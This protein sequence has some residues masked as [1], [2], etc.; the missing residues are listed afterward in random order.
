MTTR[1]HVTEQIQGT[2]TMTMLDQKLYN[3]I[4][5]VILHTI[6]HSGCRDD[7]WKLAMEIA[8]DMTCHIAAGAGIHNA[9]PLETK[10]PTV[11]ENADRADIKNA[12]TRDPD[13]TSPLWLARQVTWAD[14]WL[15]QYSHPAPLPAACSKCNQECLQT[16]LWLINR[17]T[18]K[19]TTVDAEFADMDAIRDFLDPRVELAKQNNICPLEHIDA[20]LAGEDDDE[21]A[22]GGEN[23]PGGTRTKRARDTMGRFVDAYRRHDGNTDK[24]MAEMGFVNKQQVYAY[25]NRAKNMGVL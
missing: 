21:D 4:L 17:H 16:E 7:L 13:D 25:K 22:A 2:D 9:T 12:P 10:S 1:L 23:A 11:G 3:D 5:A 6:A 24:I 19:L 14:Y 15:Y 18:H 8:A 20:E